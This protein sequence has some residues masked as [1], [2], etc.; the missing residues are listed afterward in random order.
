M[1]II[2]QIVL[3]K[4]NSVNELDLTSFMFTA[5]NGFLKV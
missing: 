5:S 3:L 1:G 2:R 4:N